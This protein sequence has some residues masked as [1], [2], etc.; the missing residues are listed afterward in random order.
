MNQSRVWSV[1]V[2]LAF[3]R[4]ADTEDHCQTRTART[5]ASTYRAG[6]FEN[7]H[8][9]CRASCSVSCTST[10]TKKEMAMVDW[11]ERESAKKKTK[12]RRR[13]GRGRRKG[14]S[15]LSRCTWDKRKGRGLKEDSRWDFRIFR[16]SGNYPSRQNGGAVRL[17]EME[18]LLF[19]FF[20]KRTIK[21]KIFKI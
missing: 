6:L 10:L 3:I 13:K 7:N 4:P 14:E 19:F 11:Y 17:G 21:S 12:R 8:D 1:A 20:C 5:M 9:H 2:D 18:Y 15:A 16:F